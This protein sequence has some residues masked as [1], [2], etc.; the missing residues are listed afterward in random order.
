MS[1][2]Q[3]LKEL[4][5][6]KLRRENRTAKIVETVKEDKD[7]FCCAVCYTDGSTSG[8]V[9]P[10]CCTHKICLDCYTKI[11]LLNKGRASCPECRTLYIKKEKEEPDLYA[12][13]PP[14]ISA[15]EII[16]RYLLEN[17]IFNIINDI[18]YSYNIIQNINDINLNN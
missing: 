5:L 6:E 12:D 3:F 10:A 9:T 1:S 15:Q 8:L 2:N 4:H 7:P 14:L 13:M 18:N 11:T 16:S 17:E